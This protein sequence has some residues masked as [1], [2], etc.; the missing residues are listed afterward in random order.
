ME[1]AE[2]FKPASTAAELIE[3][4]RTIRVFRDDP[5]PDELL[6]QLLNVA[7]WAPNHGLREPWRFILFKDEGRRIFTDAVIGSFT[8]EEKLKYA[9]ARTDYYMGIPVHLVVI[10]KEDPRQKQWEEDFAAVCCLIQNFQL[11]AW[12]KGIGVVW[13]T[14]PYIYN[15]GFRAAIGVRPGEKVIGALH[16]GYPDIIPPAR[17][18]TAAEKLL[19]VI[20]CDERR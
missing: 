3:A 5:V 14:N 19:T 11:A 9:S 4:R 10:L 8:P 7:V 6:L 2:Q 17:P 13:K 1:K 16:V 18:R 15:P 20:D 12:E